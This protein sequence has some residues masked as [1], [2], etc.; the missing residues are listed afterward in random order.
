ME[1]MQKGK[2]HHRS[3]KKMLLVQKD[4]NWPPVGKMLTMD[5]SDVKDGH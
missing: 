2:V 4:P 1:K 3:S 5:I